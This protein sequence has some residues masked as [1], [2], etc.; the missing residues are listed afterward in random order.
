M[1]QWDTLTRMTHRELTAQEAAELAGLSRSQINRDAQNGKLPV[2]RT[3]PGY[4][5]PRLFREADVRRTY[6]IAS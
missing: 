5:G 4:K 6:G 2:A 1:A 3:F